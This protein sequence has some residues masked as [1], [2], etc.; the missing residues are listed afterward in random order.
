MPRLGTEADWELV[1]DRVETGFKG[2]AAAG[3]RPG[4]RGR[5]LAWSEPAMPQ[6]E[7]V[8][9]GGG[10]DQGGAFDGEDEVGVEEA[11]DVAVASSGAKGRWNGFL[12]GGEADDDDRFGVVEGGWGV[13]AEVERG[14]SS[15]RRGGRPRGRQWRG[16]I[17]TCA[18]WRPL[19][20]CADEIDEGADVGGVIAA[21]GECGWWRPALMK[22]EPR[23]RWREW[24]AMREGFAMTIV[25]QG[26]G[27]GLGEAC[28]LL[29]KGAFEAVG[30]GAEV[31]G[32]GEEVA[33]LL[34]LD[35]G[36]V[37]GARAASW[38]RGSAVDAGLLEAGLV[39]IL[40]GA[41]E[42][43]GA[44]LDRGTEG[45]EVASGFG[46]EEEDGLLGL[47]GYGD[48]DALFADLFVPGFDADEPVVGR[49]VGRAAQEGRDEE[50]VDG[51]G[52]GQV[53]V[54]PDLVAGQQ[55]GDRGDG[56]QD[57]GAGDADID[58]GAGE[59]EAGL[60][61]GLGGQQEE[62][63]GDAAGCGKHGSSLDAGS[64]GGGVWSGVRIWTDGLDWLR[65]CPGLKSE[66]WRP[67]LFV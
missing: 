60:A 66:T 17:G 1:A 5:S 32:A 2:E 58:L 57:A 13:E 6:N 39:E 52:G 8:G 35:F 61:V 67:A 22:S 38:R 63:Q 34:E 37:G 62:S 11:G 18:V 36:G 28:V 43:A 25:E 19:R 23:R 15:R 54:Q 21:G 56:E 55:V 33:V 45:A 44:A 49:W 51:L 26:L 59:V 41:D 9:E 27:A 48:G 31:E 29:V 64:G 4:A 20:G 42:D 24:R 50:V 53:G 47:A 40:G 7:L 46:G 10:E 14:W 30:I 3:R 65:R 12:D 16:C